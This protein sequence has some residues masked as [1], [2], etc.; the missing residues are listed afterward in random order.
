M[1]YIQCCTTKHSNIGAYNPEARCIPILLILELNTF[2]WCKSLIKFLGLVPST[3]QKPEEFQYSWHS[4]MLYSNHAKY[5][6]MVLS[7]FLQQNTFQWH[8]RTDMPIL[9]VGRSQK[10]SNKQRAAKY[11]QIYWRVSNVEGDMSR[12]VGV[13]GSQLL[14]AKTL[15]FA[16]PDDHFDLILSEQAGHRN[17]SN[18]GNEEDMFLSQ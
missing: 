10:Y 6:S 13:G 12:L 1:E 9:G 4:N 17:R 14:P 8:G 5:V 2:E 15:L 3:S 11:T 7:T 18:V 16:P